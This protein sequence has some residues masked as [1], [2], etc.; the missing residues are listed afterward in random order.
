MCY[1]LCCLLAT[2]PQPHTP[3]ND[4]KIKALYSL[5]QTR[6]R[7]SA[8]VTCSP[9]LSHSPPHSTTY[10]T[11][12]LHV[13]PCFKHPSEPTFLLGWRGP[14]CLH[15]PLCFLLPHVDTPLDFFL[16]LSYP[17]LPLCSFISSI[18]LFCSCRCGISCHVYRRERQV[19]YEPTKQSKPDPFPPSPPP[20][21]PFPSSPPSS[22]HPPPRPSAR[23]PNTL[24]NH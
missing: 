9:V 5:R 20:S 19:S 12:P 3:H 4:N 23:F 1:L 11:T 24:K 15:T 14:F 21:L 6:L 7:C 18:G 2:T 17:P 16:Q 8:K 10:H 13:C 22:F